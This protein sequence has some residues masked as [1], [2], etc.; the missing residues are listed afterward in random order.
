MVVRVR[1][2]WSL[3]YHWLIASEFARKGSV[4]YPTMVQLQVLYLTVPTHYQAGRHTGRVFKNPFNC[5]VP[6]NTKGTNR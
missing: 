4:V 1:H 3:P 6:Y 5:H 2:H